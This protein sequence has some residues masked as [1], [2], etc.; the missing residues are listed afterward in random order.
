MATVEVG[1]VVAYRR[2]GG[3]YVA[4]EVRLL[5]ARQ[6]LLARHSLVCRSRCSVRSVDQ[7]LAGRTS[8]I[9]SNPLIMLSLRKV[10]QH[11]G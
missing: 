9:D 2:Y 10:A 4:D 6:D 7:T 8:L 11:Q 1:R 5:P 3:A